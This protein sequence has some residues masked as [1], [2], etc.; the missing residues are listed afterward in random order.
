MSRIFS[1][2]RIS[3]FSASSLFFAATVYCDDINELSAWEDYQSRSA[4]LK[5]LDDDFLQQELEQV[6]LDKPIP[7]ERRNRFNYPFNN[8]PN[9][10]RSEQAI[11]FAHNIISFQTPSGGWSK[12]TEMMLAPRTLGQAFGVEKKY[13]PTFDNNATTAQMRFL[14]RV[15]GATN[16]QKI[17]AAL[18]RAVDFIV[19]AQYPN[20]C[21][22]QTF[23]LVGDY[24]DHITFNDRAMVNVL[25]VLQELVKGE[26]QFSF[27]SPLIN[28]LQKESIQTSVEKGVACILDSQVMVDGELTAWGAQHDA[29]TLIPQSARAYEMASLASQESQEI[30]EFLMEQSNPSP[31]L[32]DA[33]EA[34][35]KWFESSAIEG[36][37]WFRGEGV[38]ELRANP[39]GKLLW[40][41]FYE[42]GSNRPVFGDRDG[43]VYFD[44]ME[45]SLE[46]RVN[47]RWYTDDP[48][49]LLEK[50]Q[51]WKTELEF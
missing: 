18:I 50:Y 49:G 3:I 51:R 46:R 7:A 17:G 21:W 22:P 20:G 36:K 23:P 48:V 4:E 15:F 30:V 10:Y 28:D 29:L 34:A 45:V 13:I 8:E 33:V 43:K 32:V 37:E 16:D 31:R 12:R 2:V 25:S 1:L 47:Y 26:K 9:W 27:S 5:K 44:V 19:A 41:R 24:H 39:G 35:F 42:L 14:A 11:Q 38:A 40:S 6:N